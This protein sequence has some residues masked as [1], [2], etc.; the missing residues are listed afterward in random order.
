MKGRE[1]PRY[2]KIIYNYNHK[3][4]SLE[5][6]NNI[7]LLLQCSRTDSLD[8]FFKD[9][10]ISAVPKIAVVG[11]GCSPATEPVAEISYHWNITQVYIF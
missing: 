2:I 8:E 7:T 10:E 1:I 4:I 6:V 5:L 9:M 3:N 11:C